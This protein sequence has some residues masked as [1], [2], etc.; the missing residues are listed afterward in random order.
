[1][2][3]SSKSVG[4]SLSA[5]TK[6]NQENKSVGDHIGIKV[7]GQNG[8]EVYFKIKKTTK[9]SKVFDVWARR[10]A[11]ST[12]SLRFLYDGNRIRETDTPMDIGVEDGD[13]VDVVLQQTGG[14]K[15]TTLF[16]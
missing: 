1:M 12:T 13:I 15:S 10:Q 6:V 14:S 16:R 3:G 8:Q 2:E 11:T 7:V 5:E 9:F 4:T